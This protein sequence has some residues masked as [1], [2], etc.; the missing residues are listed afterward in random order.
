MGVDYPRRDR[1][2]LG[3]Q[4]GVGWGSPDHTMTSDLEPIPPREA[5]DLY[6]D[7]RRG[8]LSAWTLRAYRSR[9]SIFVE[10]CLDEE[11]LTNLN[12]LTGRAIRRF[13]GTGL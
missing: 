4:A 3:I 12:D 10:W 7:D 9:S 8:D 5:L 2:P 6:L 1:P 11:G 13:K